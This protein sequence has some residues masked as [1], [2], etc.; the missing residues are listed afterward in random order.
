MINNNTIST[1]TPIRNDK[2]LINYYT[3]HMS[4][5]IFEFTFYKVKL[6]TQGPIYV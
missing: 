2:C 4:G 3:H 5:E 1:L 6:F